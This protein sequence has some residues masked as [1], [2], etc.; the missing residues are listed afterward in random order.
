MQALENLKKAP[1]QL[2]Q[3]LEEW[4]M[5]DGLVMFRGLVYIPN[6]KEICRKILKLFHDSPAAGHP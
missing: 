1:V 4:N 2:H 5:E 6:N 3:G